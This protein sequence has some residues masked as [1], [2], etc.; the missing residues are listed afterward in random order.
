MR[1]LDQEEGS[2]TRFVGASGVRVPD[3]GTASP[4]YTSGCMAQEKREKPLLERYGEI[5]VHGLQTAAAG[6]LGAVVED[7]EKQIGRGTRA[8][9]KIASCRCH[10]VEARV[11]DGDGVEEIVKVH[12]RDCPARD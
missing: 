2:S 6:A 8:L 4:C 7:V 12:A 10:P 11:V 1:S 9:K 5:L 3:L